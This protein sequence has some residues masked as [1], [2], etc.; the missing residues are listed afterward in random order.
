MPSCFHHERSVAESMGSIL[1]QSDRGFLPRVQAKTLS[2]SAKPLCHHSRP[3]YNAKPEYS[4]WLRLTE[5]EVT[6]A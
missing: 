1:G 5:N 6:S 3:Q 2:L 4:V